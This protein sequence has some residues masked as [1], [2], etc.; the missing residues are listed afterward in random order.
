MMH[1]V[2]D[3]HPTMT[4]TRKTLGEL[5]I[6]SK[7]SPVTA[8]GNQDFTFTY[9]ATEA[10]AGPTVD[11]H[12]LAQVP[13]DVIEIRLPK[14]WPSPTPYNF[15]TDNQLVYTATDNTVT[16]LK[17][18]TGPHVYLSGSLSRLQG[19]EISVIDG[20]NAITILKF[21]GTSLRIQWVRLFALC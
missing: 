16:M 14:N 3:R 4:V 13:P 15:D 11:A 8:G 9:K 20:A 18:A 5:T 7:T 19:A 12:G 1:E 6:K 2:S 21:P 10:L 17:D